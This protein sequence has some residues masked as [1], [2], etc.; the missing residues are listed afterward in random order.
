MIPVSSF[1]MCVARSFA[2]FHFHKK[3]WDV[4][5]EFV[6]RDCLPAEYGGPVGSTV[7]FEFGIKYLLKYEEFISANR[8]YGIIKTKP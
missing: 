5:H 3:N 6:G 8:Q 7:D 2:Q 4:L 1:Y